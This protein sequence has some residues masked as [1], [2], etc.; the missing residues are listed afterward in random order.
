MDEETIKEFTGKKCLIILKNNFQYTA[1]IPKLTKSS[2]TIS[3]KFGDKIVIECG[4][5][6]YI[7]EK[8]DRGEHDSKTTTK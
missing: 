6:A 5:I 4:F 1:I 8:N 2:F 7:A 3:D